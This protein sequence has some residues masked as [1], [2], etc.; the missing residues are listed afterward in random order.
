MKRCGKCGLDLDESEFNRNTRK[1]DGLQAWCRPCMVAFQ[2]ERRAR[3]CGDR[4]P[5]QRA[6]PR[7]VVVTECEHGRPLCAGRYDPAAD[8][9]TRLRLLVR[10]RIDPMLK[11]TMQALAGRLQA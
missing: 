3:A 4:R 10:P 1:P 6:E 11:Y 2:R 8:T 5:W 7:P 9:R